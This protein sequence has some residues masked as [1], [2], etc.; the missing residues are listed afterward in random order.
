MS[1]N[2]TIIL[3]ALF[4]LLSFLG[5]QNCIGPFDQGKTRGTSTGNPSLH[6][7][8]EEYDGADPHTKTQMLVAD[9]S[10]VSVIFCFSGLKFVTTENEEEAEGTEAVKDIDFE[11]REV[12]VA[13]LGTDLGF[14]SIPVAN[15]RLIRFD[16]TNSCPSGASVQ[17]ENA[18]GTFVST[19]SMKL[20]FLGD[21]DVNFDKEQ[22]QM[23]IKTVIEAL[24]QVTD[25]MEIKPIIESIQGRFK[26]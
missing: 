15:Y 11:P 16:I 20:R 1:K 23:E 21:M 14:A 26:E 6:L 7:S 17:L 10:D 18:N 25:A 8:F 3:F 24:S 12:S 19:Q 2:K 22:I 9:L 13:P 5:F 4:S